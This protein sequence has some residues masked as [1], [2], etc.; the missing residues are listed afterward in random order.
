M[1][2]ALTVV[3][4]CLSL[5]SAVVAAAAEESERL[6][7][8]GLVEFH[9]NRLSEALKLFDQ[10]VQA[11][12][13]NIDALY[14]RGVTH[15]R[16]DDVKAA[17][18]DLRAVVAARPNFVQAALDLGVALVQAG[19]FAEAIPWLEKAQKVADFS[20]QAS[21]FLGLAQLRLQRTAEARRN[22]QLAA[23]SDSSLLLPA[24]YYE[25]VAGYQEQNWKQAEDDFAF[26]VAISPGSEMGKEAAAF[27]ETL[28][29]GKPAAQGGARAPYQLYADV[30]FQY[31][32]NVVLA[33]GQDVLKV[34]NLNVGRREDGRAVFTVGGLY[35]P[36]Q[37]ERLQ[38]LIGYEFY[39]SLHFHRT[40][41]NLQDNRPSIQLIVNEGPV[42]LGMLGRYDFYL[43]SD[44]TF[45]QEAT[46]LPWVEVSEGNYGRTEL[47]Y[48]MRRRDFLKQ[49]FLGLR[50][51]FNHAAGLR[52]LAYLGVQ[53][54]YLWVNYQFDREDPINA[55]GNQFAYDGQEVGG[56]VG[57][58]FP[59]G[60]TTELG[61]KY[62]HERYAQ[63]SLGR[64]DDEHHVLFAAE[65]PLN[66]WLDVAL[67]YFGTINNSTE[68]TFQYDRNIV[69]LSMG[70]RF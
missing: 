4:L 32:S 11:D 12:P 55:I 60:I 67:E 15:G 59:W 2:R 18:V 42:R 52:Q 20:A 35:A 70:V 9:A 49:P 62:R 37:T 33:P 26:V 44:N 68:S 64:R 25:G 46:A 39:Q 19:E 48:R 38:L 43:L 17:V 10:A 58:A 63:Q 7:A 8:R 28:R 31:D 21:L 36:W 13:Q 50:D 23:T 45:L 30:G 53:E 41:F 69:S 56:G 34:Q 24:R 29:Q 6:Y 3:L 57:W 5:L 16:L 65:K 22:L 47:Y 61:Y 27:L 51:A 66:E 54:R 14:Y 1:V 40:D